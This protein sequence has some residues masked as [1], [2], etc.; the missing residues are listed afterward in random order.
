MDI[1]Q[2]VKDELKTRRL[3]YSSLKQLK[4]S[5][6]HF[7]EYLLSNVEPTR[8]MIIGSV[9]DCLVLTPENFEKEYAVIPTVDRRTKDGK[10]IYETWVAENKDKTHITVDQYETA[11]CMKLSLMSNEI[12]S[13]IINLEGTVQKKLLWSHKKTGL[14]F[15][16]YADKYCKECI[17]DLKSC[18]DASP[19]AF[20][21]N[22]FKLGYPLQAACY[23]SATNSIYKRPFIYVCVENKEPYAVAVYQSSRDFIEYGLH[24]YERL[25]HRL[26]DCIQNECFHQSYDFNFQ[27]IGEK[28]QYGIVDIPEWAKR[29]LE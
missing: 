20:E 8:S 5:P 4:K 18:A 7:A 11:R 15:V 10:I 16:G 13:Q 29:E 2:I 21:R 14:N 28:N 6:K 22:A 25:V 12:G 19:E 9:F 23:L 24:E 26:K 3:S 17:I 1:N 27:H